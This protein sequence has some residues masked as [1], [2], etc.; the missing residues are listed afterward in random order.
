MSDPNATHR[1]SRANL[2]PEDEEEQGQDP[3]ATAQI[4][5]EDLFPDD[6]DSGKPSKG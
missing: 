6:K 4:S 5:R 3:N 2:F 1:I